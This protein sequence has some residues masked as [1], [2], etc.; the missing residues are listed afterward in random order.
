MKHWLHK[1]M[2]RSRRLAMY[3]TGEMAE[4]QQGRMRVLLADC[5]ACRREVQAYRLLS[6]TLRALPQVRLTP[7]EAAVFW[8]S[9]EG[10][11]RQGETPAARPARPSFRELYWDHPRLSLISATAAIVLVLGLTLGPRVGWGPGTHRSNGTEVISVEAG[12]NTSV[13]LFQAPDSSL[14]FIWVFETPSS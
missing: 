11:I 9:V 8:P 14:K 1:V 4:T 13:M 3:A 6:D 10:R 7:G 12:E 5:P 2:G